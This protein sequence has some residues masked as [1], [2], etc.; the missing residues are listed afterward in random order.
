M[1]DAKGIAQTDLFERAKSGAFFLRT[2]N[3][4]APKAGIM[5]ITIFRRDIEISA[6]N[7]VRKRFLRLRH[8]IAQLNEP[9]QFVIERRRADH[10]SV[11]CVNRKNAHV[12]DRCRD[13]SCLRIFAFVAQ[14]GLAFVQLVPGKN[15]NAVV[16]FLAVKDA[17]IACR[18]QCQLGKLIITALCFLQANDIR[19]FLRQPIKQ[20]LLALAQ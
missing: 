11:R 18:C 20:T 15:R 12:L 1:M 10:L 3:G 17:A 4:A 7:Y 9:L 8:A 2:H 6:Y 5:H 14:R 19:L 13:H 16:R